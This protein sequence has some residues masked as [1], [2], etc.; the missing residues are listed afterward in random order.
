MNENEDGSVLTATAGN[1][2]VQDISLV[3]T[4]GNVTDYVDVGWERWVEWSVS[5]T[6]FLTSVSEW[7]NLKVE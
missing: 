1:V 7:V 2:D 4:I 5:F 6:P 3:G